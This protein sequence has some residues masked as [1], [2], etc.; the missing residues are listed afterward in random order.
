M[1]L[2][3]CM[4]KLS[5]I[6]TIFTPIKKIEKY[7]HSYLIEI[8]SNGD[9]ICKITKTQNILHNVEENIYYMSKEKCIEMF[10]ISLKDLEKD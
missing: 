2:I 1:S 7:G 10:K 8:E 4:N 9:N 5:K 3:Y 6:A